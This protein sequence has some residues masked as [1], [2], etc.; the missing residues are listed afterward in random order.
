MTVLHDYLRNLNR[1]GANYKNGRS[2]FRDGKS[3]CD[4]P[5][6]GTCWEQSNWLAGWL[7]E[8]ADA[9]RA[10]LSELGEDGE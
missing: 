6:W 10:P 3:I 1:D 2:D 8:L 9:V 5:R 4:A 7:D